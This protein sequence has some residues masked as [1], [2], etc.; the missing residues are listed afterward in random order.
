VLCEVVDVKR[1]THFMNAL[2]SRYRVFEEINYKCLLQCYTETVWKKS[3]NFS[4]YCCNK[5]D[6]YSSS[7]FGDEMIRQ[8][9]NTIYAVL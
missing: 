6:G 2:F 3:T 4:V 7:R 5:F 1:G 8:R 9:T